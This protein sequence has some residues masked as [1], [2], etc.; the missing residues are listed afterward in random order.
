MVGFSQEHVVG[1]S[2]EHV[3]D[4]SQEAHV[5]LL[6]CYLLCFVFLFF[7]FYRKRMAEPEPQTHGRTSMAESEPRGRFFPGNPWQPKM[8]ENTL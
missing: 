6:F 2:L 8:A 4:F 7:F 1:F 5:F 3:V